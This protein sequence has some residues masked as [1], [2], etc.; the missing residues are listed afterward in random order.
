MVRHMTKEEIFYSNSYNKLY[1]SVS[2]FSGRSNTGHKLILLPECELDLQIKTCH[3]FL[4]QIFIFKL[5][6]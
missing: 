6:Q 3:I 1:I 5:L 2:S 4:N